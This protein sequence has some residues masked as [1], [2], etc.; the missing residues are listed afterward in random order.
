LV[1]F[2]NYEKSVTGIPD[3]RTAC[4]LKCKL[5]S[6]KRGALPRPAC[7]AE[8]RL[9]AVMVL[10]CWL[11]RIE[12]TSKKETKKRQEMKVPIDNVACINLDAPVLPAHRVRSKRTGAIRFRV[13]CRFCGRW[14]YHGPATGHREA[15]CTSPSSPYFRT[16]YDLALV[17]R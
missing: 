1:G 16:G 13:W 5:G 14:H 12:L 9:V 11:G 7:Y 4:S 15:H 2:L 8:G 17:Q 10:A 3:F 6:E